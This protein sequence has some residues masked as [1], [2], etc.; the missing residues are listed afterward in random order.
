M[1]KKYRIEGLDCAACATKL[2][3]KLKKI[4][5]VNNLYINFMFQKITI[6]ANDTIFDNVLEL[7]KKEASN[8]EDGV[9]IK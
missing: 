7:V 8:F 5:G 6:D 3:S 4:K 9:I 2:E 1:V